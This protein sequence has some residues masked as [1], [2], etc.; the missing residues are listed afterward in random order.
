MRSLSLLLPLDVSL[1]QKYTNQKTT[2]SY[3]D[4]KK[5]EQ[6]LNR[7]LKKITSRKGEEFKRYNEDEKKTALLAFQLELL[8]SS[9]SGNDVFKIVPPQWETDTGDW[10]APW[11]L[12]NKGEGSPQ[13]AQ[14][15][16]LWR[17]LG[18]AYAAKDEAGWHAAS[19]AILKSSASKSL[20]TRLKLEVMQNTFPPFKIS[21]LF[22][23]AAF[24]AA[25]LFFVSANRMS[26]MTSVT[27]LAI[28]AAV[29]GV[30]LGLRVFLLAR[31]PVGTLYESLLFV[32]LITVLISFLIERYIKNGTG[33]LI[34]SLSGL[35]LGLLSFS[36]AGEGD[37]MQMLTAVLNTNFWLATHV[38]CITMGYGWCILAAVF[39][40]LYLAAAPLK[41][42]K[43]KTQQA[44][45]MLHSLTIIAL[46][47]TAIGTILG[48]IWAD[49]SWGR[50]WGWDPKENGAL[51]I[52]LWIVW[53]LHGKLG[54]QLSETAFLAGLA[55]LNVI[56]GISWIGVN[57]LGV[58]LHSYGFADGLF[59]GLALFILA[60]ILL[61]GFLWK[62]NR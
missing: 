39:A 30:G 25:L 23:A 41:I 50:F 59:Y 14:L 7:D 1:P 43:F 45:F 32:S 18:A 38:L 33:V 48:G 8:S 26:Y 4:L 15:L 34:G 31:P 9:A 52:V 58:G 60:E 55:F 19:S 40:H 3:L 51:L 16:S 56:V 10:H 6:N 49:Q 12:L 21:L 17:D 57:L 28:G 37:T 5:L 53:L 29:Q 62:K 35:F 61:I 36:F 13:T 24:I 2:L 46:L 47:F 42:E 54:R 27:T 20:Q 11:E 22:Y 44:H